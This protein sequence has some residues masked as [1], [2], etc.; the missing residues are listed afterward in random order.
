VPFRTAH[1]G[2][3]KVSLDDHLQNYIKLGYLEK[4]KDAVPG[5]TQGNKRGRGKAA[6]SDPDAEYTWKWGGRALAE[7]GEAAV[8]EF[9]TSILVDGS[10][11]LDEDEEEA[12]VEE[13]REKESDIM[14]KSITK[15]A[16]GYL[17]EDSK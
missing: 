4:L 9:M 12:V 14:R 2:N 3:K 1:I 6:S 15:A 7:I 11:A 8:V 10:F 16:G 13:K 5:V 17:Y